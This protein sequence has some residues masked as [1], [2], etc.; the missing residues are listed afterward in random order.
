MKSVNVERE[1]IDVISDFISKV[2]HS[3]EDD[4][5]FEGA[6]IVCGENEE[7]L[8]HVAL[9]LVYIDYTFKSDVFVDAIEEVYSKTGICVS[10]SEHPYWMYGGRPGDIYVESLM[11]GEI[12]Y[13]RNDNL[14]QTK[15]LLEFDSE[16]NLVMDKVATD[17][18]IQY[19]K[20]NN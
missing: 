2:V 18:P 11:M 17:P 16:R 15:R 12:V 7:L 13:D 5:R 10:V 6:Y 8:T 1:R 4:V 20:V 19:K 9:H 3:Y 14:T